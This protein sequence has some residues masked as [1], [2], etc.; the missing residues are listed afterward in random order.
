MVNSV[1]SNE[2]VYFVPALQG[3]G[4]PYWDTSARGLITGITRKTSRE[5]LVR[6]ALESLAYQS[7][8]VVRVMEDALGRRIERLRVDG[9]S[10]QSDFL[11]QF[12]A[13][14]LGIPVER[15]AMIETTALGAAGLC[16][17][18]CGVWS[19]EALMKVTRPERYFKPEM[20]EDKRRVLYGAWKA[21][22]QKALTPREG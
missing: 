5:T 17:I 22:I 9:G 12:Q 11:M 15:P 16:G 2:G 3:L 1:D 8:D 18:A 20:S 19:E 7:C 6:A 13:D 4:A 14:L 10:A 21:A